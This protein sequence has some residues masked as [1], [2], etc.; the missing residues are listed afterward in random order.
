LNGK[1]D[2]S[3]LALFQ[4]RLFGK[5]TELFR[6]LVLRLEDFRKRELVHG[7]LVDISSMVRR[8]NGTRSL[9]FGRIIFRR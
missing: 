9:M 1:E 4:Q 6:K 7:K 3:M 5:F 8:N 2:K